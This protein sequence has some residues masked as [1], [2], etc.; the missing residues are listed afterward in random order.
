[1]I[2][3]RGQ[4]IGAQGMQL[5]RIIARSLAPHLIDEQRH[6]NGIDLSGDG[7]FGERTD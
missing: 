2:K 5:S 1:V 6:L 7:Q 4:P 3:H